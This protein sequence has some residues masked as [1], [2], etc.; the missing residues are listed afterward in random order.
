MLLGTLITLGLA[1]A[2][3]VGTTRW[4]G[5]DPEDERKVFAQEV[6]ASVKTQMRLLPQGTSLR[7]KTHGVFS[8]LRRP[9]EGGAD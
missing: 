4:H 8:R 6:F 1:L 2:R 3:I 9:V 5:I 7:S